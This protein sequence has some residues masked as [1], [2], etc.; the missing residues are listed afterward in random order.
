MRLPLG[1]TT[2]SLTIIRGFTLFWLFPVS[3]LVGLVSIQ[4]VSLFWPTLVGIISFWLRTYAHISSQKNYL[5]RHAWQSEVLQSFIPTLLVALLALLIPLILLLI[6][7]K[8]HTITTLS[9][10]HD[11]MMQRYYKFLI[12]NVLVFF[13]VGTAALQ[14]FLQSFSKSANTPG[15]IKIVG[16]SFPTGGPFYVG[17][18]EFFFL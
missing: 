3:L 10:L 18:R 13:C 2:I 12:V 7:K 17:W 15:V 9:A 14:S 8:A 5:D 1:V 11:L 4:N 6:A 16:D